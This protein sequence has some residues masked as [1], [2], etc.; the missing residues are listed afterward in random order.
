MIVSCQESE[1]LLPPSQ[2]PK[3][4]TTLE[5]RSPSPDELW[6]GRLY[7]ADYE[8]GILS[9]KDRYSLDSSIQIMWNNQDSLHLI[10]RYYA[11]FVSNETCVNDLFEEV[12]QDT[13][14]NGT[15]ETLEL[16]QRIISGHPTVSSLVVIESSGVDS[17]VV[18]TIQFTMY[19]HLTN[20]DA[21]IIVGDELWTFGHDNITISSATGLGS[22]SKVEEIHSFWSNSGDLQIDGVISP[23]Y[24]D[25]CT[26][27]YTTHR[28]RRD[29][30]FKGRRGYLTATVGDEFKVVTKHEKRIARLWWRNKAPVIFVSH[31]G[32]RA[33]L[34]C[35]EGEICVETTTPFLGQV[36][37]RN[38][39]GKVEIVMF[40]GIF[41]QTTPEGCTW[42]DE[43]FQI[44]NSLHGGRGHNGSNTTCGGN[45]P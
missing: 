10:E 30:W 21:K 28:G 19:R 35:C 33:T 15:I 43:R 13:S 7:N 26:T 38:D 32:A 2:N 11:G 24:Y 20:C 41:D 8:N 18:E 27:R 42:I 12:E 4:K 1:E 6:E 22:G 14:E 23:R 16:A 17:S 34:E 40:S 39:D 31:G 25:E 44:F 9:F 5:G 3:T 45:F 37:T 29:Y 36:V